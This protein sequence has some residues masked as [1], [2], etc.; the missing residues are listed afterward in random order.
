MRMF[1]TG[2]TSLLAVTIGAGLWALP[3]TSGCEHEVSHS[4]E[5]VQHPNG[6]VSHEDTTVKEKPN[7]DVVKE[8]NAQNP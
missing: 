4:E 2:C 6:T 8:H 3:L 7:G 5:T 1:G